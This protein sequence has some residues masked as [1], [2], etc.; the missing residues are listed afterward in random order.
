MRSTEREVILG[1]QMRTELY[2]L[3]KML[4]IRHARLQEAECD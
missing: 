2:K 4:S 3:S 1:L